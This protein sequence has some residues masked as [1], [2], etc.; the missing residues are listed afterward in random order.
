M[1]E[2]LVQDNGV[3]VGDELTLTD[4]VFAVSVEFLTKAHPNV[5]DAVPKLKLLNEK[6]RSEPK[7]ADWIERRLTMEPC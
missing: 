5:L 4:V 3:F 1:L 6:V 2:N 7:I